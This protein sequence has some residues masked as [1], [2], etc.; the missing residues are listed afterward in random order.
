MGELE[1]RYLNLRSFLDF[2]D[3]LIKKMHIQ[4]DVHFFYQI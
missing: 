3:R 2:A 4:K 1:T